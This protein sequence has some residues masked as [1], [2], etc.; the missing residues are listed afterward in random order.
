MGK[1]W[2]QWQ[3]LFLGTPR[4]LQ[5]VSAA[6][7]WKALLLGRKVMTNLDNILK[8]IDIILSTNVNLVK[9]LVFPVV[10]YG[11]ENWTIKKAEHQ[12][13]DAFELQCCRR[14]LRFPKSILMEIN[15]EYSL[16]GLKLK[17]HYFGHLMGRADSLE[18]TLVLGRIAS[19][20]RRGR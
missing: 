15:P 4:S 10:I 19:R 9:A 17:L 5:M 6:M 14:L 12:R 1:Q 2:K 20:R 18:K 7:K 16:Q 3:T 8:S 11:W 13:T